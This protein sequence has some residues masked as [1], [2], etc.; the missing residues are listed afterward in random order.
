MELR[1]L[2]YQVVARGDCDCCKEPNV[3]LRFVFNP[4]GDDQLMCEKCGKK[5]D[6]DLLEHAH[7]DR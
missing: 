1:A 5:A 7:N 6:E 2:T 4:Y 3:M